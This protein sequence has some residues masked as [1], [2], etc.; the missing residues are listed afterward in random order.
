MNIEPQLAR[1]TVRRV[2]P[3]LCLSVLATTLSACATWPSLKDE[4]SLTPACTRPV[5]GRVIPYNCI[6]GARKELVDLETQAGYFNRGVAYAAVAG[7]TYAGYQASRTHPNNSLLKHAAIGLAALV[8]FSQ[9][10]GADQQIGA[11]DAGIDALDCVRKA[12]DAIK[13]EDVPTLQNNA[14]KFRRR[15]ALPIAPTGFTA[16]EVSGI[17]RLA[18]MRRLDLDQ[19]VDAYSISVANAQETVG[20]DVYNA[21]LTIREEVRRQITTKNVDAKAIYKAQQDAV[22]SLIGDMANKSKD[23]QQ[24]ALRLQVVTSSALGELDDPPATTP[25]KA[26]QDAFHACVAPAPASS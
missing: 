23:Q 4:A 17:H 19:R 26:A 25:G 7:G 6:E 5:N 3:I 12:A 15:F 14:I 20:F 11:V 24:A 21:V 10:V 16:S 9:V 1:M 18:D 8:G 22:N 13:H 2:G